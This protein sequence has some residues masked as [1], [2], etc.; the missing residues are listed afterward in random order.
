MAPWAAAGLPWLR[1]RRRFR[2]WLPAS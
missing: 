1:R 2:R